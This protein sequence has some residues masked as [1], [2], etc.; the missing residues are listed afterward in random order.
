MDSTQKFRLSRKIYRHWEWGIIMDVYG[1]CINVEPRLL[2]A[3]EHYHGE[4]LPDWRI[5]NYI[6]QALKD[7]DTPI[8]QLAGSLSDSEISVIIE[9]GLKTELAVLKTPAVNYIY[10]ERNPDVAG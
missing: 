4:R 9:N 8:I 3:H 6:R 10:G 7:K 2:Q 5:E 1:K